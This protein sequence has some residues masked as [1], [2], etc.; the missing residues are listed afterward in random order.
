MESLD[1]TDPRTVGGYPLFARLGAGG[2]GQVYLARTPAGRAL[3]LKTVRSEFGLD[4]GFGERFAREIRHADRVRSPWTVAV[5]DF[6]P[7]GTRP[8]WLATEY[9]AAPSLADWVA[10]HGPLPEAALMSLAAEL[11]EALRAVHTAGLAHRDVK[12]S[13]VLLGPDRPLLIDFGIARAAEDSRHTRTGGVIGSPGYM[14]PEQATAGASAEPG[15]LFALAAVLVY[16]ATGHG[17]FSKPGEEPSTPALMYRIVHEDADLSG[18]PEAVGPL[19]RACLVKEPEERPTADG[20][21]ALLAADGHRAG[22]WRDALPPGLADELSARQ[23]R[24]R[25][26]LADPTA[27]AGP[28]PY[29]PT[30]PLT[31]AGTGSLPGGTTAP[32][33]AAYLQRPVPG[34][35]SGPSAPVPP[36][37]P[38][39]PPRTP[40]RRPGGRVALAV[41]AVVALLVVIGIIV[42]QQ[43][44]SDDNAKNPDPSGSTGTSTSATAPS[45]AL[46]AAWVGTWAGT[47]PGDPNGELPSDDFKVT[48]TLH[49]GVRGD[50]IGQDVSNIRGTASGSEL[51]CTEALQLSQVQGNTVLLRVTSARPTDRSSPLT[52]RTGHAYTVS[53]T[54]TRTLHLDPGPQAVGAPS[55]LTK[56]G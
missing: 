5:V 49:A 32:P 1:A 15:D 44:G 43:R 48:L 45:D 47:G 14:A 46:P 39:N 36:S 20:A 26:L 25:T 9:V 51:G 10:A 17:P 52:C 55:T 11:C 28:S 6:S 41:A 8:P 18:L 42:D 34:P 3:A 23:A 4:P 19:V 33:H 2:M 13:N 24:V 7:P 31:A 37:A 56:Q 27:V 29:A 12:P 40:G 53:M 16:A 30:A 54:D 21:L 50:T 22:G 35:V 38:W